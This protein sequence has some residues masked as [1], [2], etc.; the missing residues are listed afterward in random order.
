LLCSI[1]QVT[2]NDPYITYQLTKT[3]II[4]F[5]EIGRK[6]MDI[7]FCEEWRH[8]AIFL[9]P[10]CLSIPGC[11]DSKSH[12]TEDS[13]NDPWIIAKNLVDIGKGAFGPAAEL[14][15]GKARLLVE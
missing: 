8:D 15:P 11:L 12:G 9:S 13:G 10:G 3:N 5:S 4:C 14:Q 2:Q 6:I 1:T 7:I